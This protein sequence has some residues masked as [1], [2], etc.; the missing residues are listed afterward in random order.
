MYFENTCIFF[1]FPSSLLPPFPASLPPS[2]SLYC[3][4]LYL[5]ALSRAEKKILLN[6]HEISGS[7][8]YFM[9]NRK[10]Q[11]SCKMPSTNFI[12]R[13]LEV[14]IWKHICIFWVMGQTEM[15][16]LS[17]ANK[18]VSSFLALTSVVKNV[19]FLK[20]YLCSP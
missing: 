14:C 18:H 20:M 6:Y 11:R 12:L 10:C 2:F 13:T 7:Q 9:S 1:L 16:S 4:P 8:R 17:I 5:L 19:I 3:A 15:F